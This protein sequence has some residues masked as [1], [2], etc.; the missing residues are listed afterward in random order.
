VENGFDVFEDAPLTEPLPLDVEMP[1][2]EDLTAVM[3]RVYL[4]FI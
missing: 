1:E 2:I 3:V 4:M